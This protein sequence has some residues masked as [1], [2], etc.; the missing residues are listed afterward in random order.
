MTTCDSSTTQ[1][2][3]DAHLTWRRD[4][5][6]RLNEQQILNSIHESHCVTARMKPCKRPTRL[7]NGKLAKGDSS[8]RKITRSER[9]AESAAS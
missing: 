6:V 8:R 2:H 7:G 3:Q 5:G 1:E 9:V 4:R